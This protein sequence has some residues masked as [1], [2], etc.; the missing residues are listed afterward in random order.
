[1]R[2]NFDTKLSDFRGRDFLDADGHP[3]T[4]RNAACA[5]LTNIVKGDENASIEDKMTRE[6]LAGRIWRNETPDLPVE[7]LALIKNRVNLVFPSAALVGAFVRAME[8]P[9]VEG[10]RKV[11]PLASVQDAALEGFEAT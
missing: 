9:P 2:V 8:N 1:M 5:A 6:D 4:M 10:E 3:L 7:Q 11:L